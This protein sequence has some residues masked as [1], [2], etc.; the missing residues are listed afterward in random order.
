MNIISFYD[1][2]IAIHVIICS[3]SRHHS[4]VVITVVISLRN[5]I[6][7]T[8]M[9]FS[10]HSHRYTYTVVHSL[11]YMYFRLTI[12]TDKKKKRRSSRRRRRNRRG[13][14]DERSMFTHLVPTETVVLSLFYV[15]V[16]TF[17][18]ENTK[19]VL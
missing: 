13:K 12:R 14:Y 8:I 4:P 5:N 11:L 18:E 19:G 17:I 1:L 10:P 15:Y 3:V 7:Y 9:P 16:C 6:W 2:F